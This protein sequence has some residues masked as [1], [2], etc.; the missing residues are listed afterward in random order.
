MFSQVLN[1]SKKLRLN[2]L[3]GQPV[4]V[5]EHTHSKNIYI[6]FCGQM[7][8]PAFWFLI[9]LSF[10]ATSCQWEEPGSL[11]IASQQVFR[12]IDKTPLS[13]LF[14]RVNILSFLSFSLCSSPLNILWS[15][16]GQWKAMQNNSFFIRIYWDKQKLSGRNK[17]SLQAFLF[18]FPAFCLLCCCFVLFFPSTWEFVLCIPD[19][20]SEVYAARNSCHL[21]DYNEVS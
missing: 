14:S 20:N 3:F 2:S 16:T 7:V 18:Y 10:P 13:L 6:C 15:F 9:I 12:H 11:F 8:F 21:V 1:I 4:P 17:I 5:S 19:L